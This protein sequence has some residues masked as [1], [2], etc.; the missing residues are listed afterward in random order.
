MEVATSMAQ[1][2]VYVDLLILSWVL[3]PVKIISLVLSRVNHEMGQKWLIPRKTTW[4]QPMK[5]LF[6]DYNEKKPFIYRWYEPN[7][8]KMCLMSYANNKGAD[9]PAHPCSLISA[10]VVRCLDSVISL[11]FYSWN[12][13]TLASF[14]S[15]AGQF[16][17]GLVGNS[18]R[19]I[20]SCH[21]SYNNIMLLIKYFRPFMGPDLLYWPE[22]EGQYSQPRTHNWANTK[23]LD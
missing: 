6:I 18:R 20:L 5:K 7:Q 10:F 11:R 16:V 1:L 3:Q 17:P 23:L 15:W 22:A 9:Q 2:H 14:C 19:H 12:F 4:H 21:G 8:E 13:K